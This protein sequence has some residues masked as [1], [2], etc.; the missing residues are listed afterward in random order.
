LKRIGARREYMTAD[1]YGQWMGTPM[2]RRDIDDLLESTGWGTLSL[3]DGGEPYS[4]P[5]SFGYDGDDV[6]FGLIRDSPTNT[7]FDFVA[8]GTTARLL[9]TD[10]RARFDWQSVAVTG[11]LRAIERDGDD[12]ETLVSRLEDNAWFSPAFERA[13][14]VEELQGW[15]LDPDEVRGIEVRPDRD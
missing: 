5:V 6:Y 15:R 7:K 1:P 13:E 8:D 11:T 2:S 3:A 9:V 4:I 14:G 12:W 10:V